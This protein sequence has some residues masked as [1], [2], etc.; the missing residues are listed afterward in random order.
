MDSQ[1]KDVP[2][3]IQRLRDAITQTGNQAVVEDFERTTEQ[4]ERLLQSRA[5]IAQLIEAKQA[6][7]APLAGV[8][9]SAQVVFA[10]VLFFGSVSATVKWESGGQCDFGAMIWG[11]GIGSAISWGTFWSDVP[12]DE[13]PGECSFSLEATSVACTMQ[14][15]RGDTYLGTYAGGGFGVGVSTSGGSGAWHCHPDEEEQHG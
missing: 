2:L 4:I 11:L 12:P 1:V 14:F 3:D 5:E 10:Q 9:G 13:L 15:W 8:S 6:K 7:A